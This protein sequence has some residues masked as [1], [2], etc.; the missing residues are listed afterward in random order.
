MVS[1]DDIIRKRSSPGIL[2]FDLCGDLLFMNQATK[3]MVTMLR[4]SPEP[5]DMRKPRVPEGIR[6]L[7]ETLQRDDGAPA[8]KSGSDCNCHVLYSEAG[9]PY[10]LRAFFIGSA[11]GEHPPTHIMVLVEKVIE[12]H[13]IDYEKVKEEFNLSKREMEVLKL[14]CQG[15]SNKEI[16]EQMFIC[17]YTVKDHVKKIMRMTNAGS[18]SEIIALLR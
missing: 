11:D 13:Q 4:D 3:S 12:R 2:I 15:L 7:F 10:S 8:G 18:R 17:E 9:I 6:N 1:L 14:I 5:T 16:A